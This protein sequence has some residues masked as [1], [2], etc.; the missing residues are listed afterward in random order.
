MPPRKKSTA[1]GAAPTA[2]TRSSA[3]TK[4][5][6]AAKPASSNH[7]TTS[8]T[9]AKPASKRK[10]VAA[11]DEEEE[12]APKSKKPASKKAKKSKATVD[13]DEDEDEGDAMDVDDK[14]EKDPKMVTVVKRGAAPVDPASKRVDTH[15]V[16]ANDEAV[17]D[18]TLNQTDVKDNKN[19]F[20]N[21]QLLHPLGNP[22]ECILF[23]H[24]GRV[25]E[26]GQNQV[27][28]PW[29]AA[30]A[31]SQFKSQFKA[32]AGVNWENRIG[33]VARKGKYTWLE[34]DYDNEKYPYGD[35]VKGKG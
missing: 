30:S 29:P 27:K 3:R 17:W 7:D 23:T 32:K 14:K 18:A 15:Q 6:Q 4:S 34:R 13:E 1:D 21:L 2:P 31:I 10:R 22:N 20:Y 12:E 35:S 33:M 24:W 26:N 28:G 25:G 8:K 9:A 5:A 11:D 19:K 16:Y